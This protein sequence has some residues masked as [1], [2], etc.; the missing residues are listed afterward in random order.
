[1]G[2]EYEFNIGGDLSKNRLQNFWEMNDTYEFGVTNKY[3]VYRQ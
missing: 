1:M 3:Y 2:Y